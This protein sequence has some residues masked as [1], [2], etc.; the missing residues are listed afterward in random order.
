MMPGA[1]QV[2]TT[3]EA[4]G[5]SKVYWD[6][7]RKLEVL[8]NA[9]LTVK[10]GEVAA[11]LGPSGS[12]K[13]TLL[14]VLSGLD[15][16]DGGSVR[17]LGQD[18]AALPEVEKARLRNRSVGFVFQFYHLL[19]EFSALENVMMPAVIA[20]DPDLRRSARDRAAALLESVGLGAR[21]THFPSELS[22]GE[23]QR[24]A[25]ARALVNDPAVLFCDEPT[26]NLDRA[27]GQEIAGLLEG[28]MRRG[29]KTAVIVTHDERLAQTADRIWDISTGDWRQR[30]GLPE[31][32]TERV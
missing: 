27:T 30:A 17:L 13:T 2:E 8:R 20:Q 21:L 9:T 7:K 25:I 23:Q 14:N 31:R 16:P 22:G 24:V 3:V 28:F 19:P 10:A 11:V 12:G 29:R 18:L 5:V 26:G 32:E 4:I 15:S 1:P 6:G